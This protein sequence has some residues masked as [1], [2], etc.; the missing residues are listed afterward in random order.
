MVHPIQYL[1]PSGAFEFT[2]MAIYG[3]LR[4]GAFDQAQIDL[5]TAAYEAALKVLQL[6]DRSDPITQ[7]IAK[8]VIELAQRGEREPPD[9]CAL[10][11][12]ELGVIRV[13]E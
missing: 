8:K 1:T 2:I 7:M 13:S 6:K 4:E 11:I 10:V 9:I 12:K 3:L 5:M